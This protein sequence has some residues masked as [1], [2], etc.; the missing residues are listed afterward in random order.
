MTMDQWA[1]NTN[2]WKA[3]EELYLVSKRAGKFKL[4]REL[5][6]A[7]YTFPLVKLAKFQNDI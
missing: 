2:E 7:G 5:T 3:E 6:K 4:T 1:K